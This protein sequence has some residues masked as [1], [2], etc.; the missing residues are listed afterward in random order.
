MIGW[1]SFVDDK[2]GDDDAVDNLTVKGPK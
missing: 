2:F 1:N